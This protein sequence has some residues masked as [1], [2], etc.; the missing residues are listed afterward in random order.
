MLY[1][2]LAGRL[3]FEANDP[4][5]LV[6]LHRNAPLPPL[7]QFR[8]DA[9]GRLESTAAAALAKDPSERPRDGGALLAELGAPAAM[10]VATSTTLL[11]DA[12]TQVLPAA[13]A[14]PPPTTA[15]P[16]TTAT[17]I[18]PPTTDTT[19]ATTSGLTITAP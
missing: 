3:P 5:E 17:T 2:M 13:G 4:L 9:P 18:P 12:A 10:G 15:L 7:S 16:P 8:P 1:R 6:L 11:D 14:A 19:G